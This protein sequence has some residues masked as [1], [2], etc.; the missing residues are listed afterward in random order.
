MK[1]ATRKLRPP[2]K[3]HGGK[4]YLA[5][6]IVKLFPTHRTY[7]ECFLGGGS[8]LL[9][10]PKAEREVAGDLDEG[11]VNFWQILAARPELIADA[12]SRVPFD[13]GS[14]R[15][16]LTEAARNPRNAV[17]YLVRNRM[18]RGALGK[19]FARCGTNPDGSPRLRGFGHPAGPLPD[20]ESAWRSIV[21]SLPAVAERVR[22]VVF[23][24]C[25][26]SALVAEWG[27]HSDALIYCDPPY[28][29][30]TRTVR[31]AYEHE[32]TEAD[33]R[34]LLLVLRAARS[35][36]VV[37]GYRCDLYDTL[38]AGWERHEFET[39]NH[40]G[41]GKTKQRRVECL[42]IKA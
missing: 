15:L 1:T 34:E 41:Q 11:L 6:R 33:H 14:F 18:S 2:V 37:S 29:H 31:D 36:A 23:L 30:A 27:G 26:A 22:D 39:P 19:D 28:V 10:K 7:V 8:V 35:K 3:R 24:C 12:A 4:F 5:D 20:N 25:E 42:W 17:S 21:E 32:M 40:S 16:S 38:L 13:E 9:N